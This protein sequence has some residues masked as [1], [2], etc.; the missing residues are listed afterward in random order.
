M[1][2]QE[3]LSLSKAIEVGLEN[4]YQ[5]KIYRKSEK[6]SELNNTW[7]NAGAYPSLEFNLGYRNTKDYNEEK[8]FMRNSFNSFF[9]CKLDFI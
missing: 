1:Q 4:N 5:L 2:A 3:E 8:D 9:G 6:V 7:G